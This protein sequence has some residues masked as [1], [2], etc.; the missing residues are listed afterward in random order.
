MGRDDLRNAQFIKARKRLTS[1]L[2]NGDEFV[3]ITFRKGVES[4]RVLSTICPLCVVD[5]MALTRADMVAECLT[6]KERRQFF[7]GEVA[8]HSEDAGGREA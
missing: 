3:L 5:R 7:Y 8:K 6:D 4:A 1:C 2:M